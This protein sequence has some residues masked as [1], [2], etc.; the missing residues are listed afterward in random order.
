VRLRRLAEPG[1]VASGLMRRDFSVF[2]WLL[3]LGALANLYF[4][5]TSTAQSAEILFAVCAYR[6]LFPTRYEGN[7]VLHDLPLS[8]IF[9]T[10][11]LATFAEIAYV[12][13]FSRVLRELNL[14][15]LKW[16]DALSW[17]MVVQVVI[18]QGLVWV[19]VLRGRLVLYV[20]EELG[21]LLIFAANTV[22]SAALYMTVDGLGGREILLSLNL[23][24]GALYL[25]WQSLH[26]G[27]LW[28]NARRGATQPTFIWAE[29]L[30]RALHW[31][32]RRTDARAWG[33]WVGLTWMTG[34]WA[35]LI[36]AWVWFVARRLATPD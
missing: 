18:S 13:L 29:G 24:F 7:V 6:C 15:G 5:A 16:V 28:A 35:S 8:S 2:L 31:R 11:L 14:G 21:W 36:P 12:F 33:G 23:L 34:Y 10:R 30:Q 17:F 32:Q 22:A 9:L 3:K 1:A 19:A 4:L 20:C 27:V 25:P 26:L